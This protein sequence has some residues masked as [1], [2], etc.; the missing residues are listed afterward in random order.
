MTL[1][2]VY[3]Y[4]EQY[5]RKNRELVL[6]FLRENEFLYFKNRRAYEENMS[7][8]NGGYEPTM[9][10][11][12][13]CRLKHHL[14]AGTIVVLP[15]DFLMAVREENQISL[16]DENDDRPGT[17]F[18]E[19]LDGSAFA[20]LIDEVIINGNTNPPFLTDEDQDDFASRRLKSLICNEGP[21]ALR[22]LKDAFK[23]FVWDVGQGSTNCIS[24]GQNLAIFDFGLSFY[25]TRSKAEKIYQDHERFLQEHSRVSL[26]ISH[27]DIDHYKMLCFVPDCFFEK[28]CCVFCPSAGMGLTYMQVVARISRFCVRRNIINSVSSRSGRKIDMIYHKPRFRLYVGRRNSNKNLSGLM[29]SVSGNRDMAFLTGDH[30]NYQVW[31]NMYTLENGDNYRL[32]VVVPH[33]GGDCGKNRVK[34]G[35]VPGIAAISVG[36]NYYGHPKSN[37]IAAY[38]EAGYRVKRTDICG[39]DIVID[40]Q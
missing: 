27:W 36:G 7:I 22:N 40:I 34:E 1:E 4:V 11:V 14:K 23:L 33:H 35:G 8:F 25:Y 24:D 37:T 26:I 31:N 28:I 30:S 21:C 29:L 16:N 10:L 5:N 9:L 39:E 3:L 38:K 2:N 12:H 20:A 15:M 13:E 18:L 19:I 32:N 17:V 6:D